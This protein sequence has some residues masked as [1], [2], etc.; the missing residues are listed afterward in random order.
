MP[1]AN[2]WSVAYARQ[3]KSDMEVRD[4]LLTSKDFP[5][6]HQLHFLQMACEKLCKAHLFAQGQDSPQFQK[7]HAYVASILP[8]IFKMKFAETY[9]RELR[10]RAGVLSQVK[11]LA[12]EIELLAPAVDAAGRRKDNCEYPW[13]DGAGKIVSPID[14]Q[15]PNLDLLHKPHGIQ[16]LKFV[17]A[18]IDDLCKPIPPAPSP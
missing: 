15:F 14:R 18:A 5:P 3:A 7:S 17:K 8:V 13:E 1:T 12:R 16:I 11:Q 4:F 2:E 6:C 10:N 9:K